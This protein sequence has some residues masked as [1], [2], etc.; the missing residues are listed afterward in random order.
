[1]FSKVHGTKRRSFMFFDGRATVSGYN[2]KG[3]GPI[4][5]QF[6]GYNDVFK[7]KNSDI[8]S[9]LWPGRKDIT[10]PDRQRIISRKNK[11]SFG[12]Q[13]FGQANP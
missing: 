4:R 13:S 12:L 7:V 3:Y 10:L 11:S 5:A 2:H 1:M 6:Y 8:G 9:R